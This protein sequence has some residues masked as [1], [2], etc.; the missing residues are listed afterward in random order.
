MGKFSDKL[1]K[2]TLYS[3][4]SMVGVNIFTLVYSI[5]L[6]RM[7]VNLHGDLGKEYL[8]IFSLMR[9]IGQVILP[10]L[11]IGI[12]TALA[13]F[14]PEYQTRKK[15]MLETLLNTGIYLVCISAVVGGIVYFILADPIAVYIFD[16]PLL[17]TLMKINSVFIVFTV[18]ITTFQ[19]ILQGCVEGVEIL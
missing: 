5:I 7:L 15:E 14:I 6:A 1:V 18:L 4:M 13:K 3:F 17:G 8:G 16:E 2:G 11:V 10:L 19:G 12:P 9:E